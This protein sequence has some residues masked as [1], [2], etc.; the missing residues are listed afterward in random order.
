MKRLIAI[1]VTG[2]IAGCATTPSGR[3]ETFEAAPSPVDQTIHSATIEDYILA[4]PPFAFHDESVEQFSEVVRKARSMDPRNNKRGRDSLLI[5]GDGL[6]PTRD[7]T[8][9]RSTN[10]LRIFVHEGEGPSAPYEAT[11]R[12]VP[13]GWMRNIS[14]Q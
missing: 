1:I 11:M 5:S 4:L 14:I 3:N 2:L 6:W 10:T 8:L 12:R 7:F 9:D 13:G